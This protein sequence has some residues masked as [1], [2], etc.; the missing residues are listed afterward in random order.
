MAYLQ[1][2]WLALAAWAVAMEQSNFRN[3]SLIEIGTLNKQLEKVNH[4]QVN[5][6]P[7]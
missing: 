5:L 6:F 4:H 7:M 3:A 1:D 2:S